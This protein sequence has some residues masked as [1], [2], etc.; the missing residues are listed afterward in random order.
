MPVEYESQVDRVVS[1]ILGNHKV[2]VDKAA[3]RLLELAVDVAPEQDGTL[4][5]SG[6]V[7]PGA[8]HVDVIE[9]AVMFDTP[10]ASRL[11]EHP[12]FNFSHDVNPRAQG[13]F[14]EDPAV[15]HMQELGAIIAAEANRG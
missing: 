1:A 7:V 12:E 13:K 5:G 3:E 14:L 2:G 6:A 4:I 8:E 11:H 10:Y 15:K 9:A